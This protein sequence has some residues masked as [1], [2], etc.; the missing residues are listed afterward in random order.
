MSS[1]DGGVDPISTVVVDVEGCRR[2]RC[3]E[4]SK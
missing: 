3:D 1:L 4:E 2:C